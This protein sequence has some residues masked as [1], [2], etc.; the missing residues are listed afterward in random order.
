MTNKGWLVITIILAIVFICS[1]VYVFG[2]GQSLGTR[3]GGG[4]GP[5]QKKAIVQKIPGGTYHTMIPEHSGWWEDWSTFGGGNCFS[6]SSDA[7]VDGRYEVH[8]TI[9]CI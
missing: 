8:I 4:A 6:V 9:L 2:W 3:V 5:L 1:A 7:F